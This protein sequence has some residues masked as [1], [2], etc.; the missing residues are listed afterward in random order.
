VVSRRGEGTTVT[1]TLPLTLAIIEGLL[2]GLDDDC[3]I[4]PLSIVDENL[5]IS[6]DDCAT[7]NARNLIALRGSLIPFVRLRELF[8]GGGARPAMERV[9]IVRAGDQRLGLVVDRI[10]GT[11]QTVV[12]SLGHFYRQTTHVSGATILGDGRVALILDVAGLVS[13]FQLRGPRVH[14]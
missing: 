14:A 8:G 5:E 11:H 1:L 13:T 6:G 7:G 3:F 4:L 12:Q 2:V 9:V 10:I